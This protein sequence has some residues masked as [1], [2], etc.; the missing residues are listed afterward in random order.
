MH[1]GFYLNEWHRGGIAILVSRLCCELNRQGHQTT[2]FLERPYPKRSEGDCLSYNRY[3]KT[4]GSACVSL[5]LAAYPPRW[6]Q[7][8][9]IETVLKHKVEC[10]FPSLYRPQASGF[11]KLSHH[12]PVAAIAHNDHS[13][14]YDEYVRAQ[15]FL[16][17]QV[18]PSHQIY[19]RCR[20]FAP[21][22]LKSKIR[23]IISGITIPP[24]TSPPPTGPLKVIYCSRLEQTQ[25]RSLELPV[26]WKSFLSQGGIGTLSIIGCGETGQAMRTA[27][28]DE[29]AAGSV[30]FFGHL[31]E[32]EV[33]RE[34]QTG[35]IILNLA[36]F[37][38]FPQSVIEG[39]AR[40]MWPLLSD[41]ESGHREI[42]ELLGHGTLCPIGD[43]EAFART[44]LDFAARIE[45]L[46]QK[47]ALIQAKAKECFNMQTCAQAYSDLARELSA[48]YTAR[49]QPAPFASYLP[50]LKERGYR[51]IL[52]ARYRRA[53]ALSWKR[54]HGNKE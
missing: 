30:R 7:S 50:T 39:T 9:L 1:I 12:I 11:E 47:R 49:P 34:L 18:A 54:R 10:I 6:R 3:K 35:D 16:A 31:E 51:L 45:E 22:E 28:A 23:H 21:P 43:K 41:T 4:V 38:G 44:L 2:L 29:Q 24:K 40:G 26:I 48:T 32:D 36:N 27:L 17:A 5:D 15:F 13:Y 8:H 42:I 14:F 25:K 53:Y 19:E 37:E 33:A 46:R 20:R 52:L